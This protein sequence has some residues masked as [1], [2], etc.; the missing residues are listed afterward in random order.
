MPLLSRSLRLPCHTEV[1]LSDF[2]V[3]PNLPNLRRVV[4]FPL[5]SF[6]SVFS[7]VN[8]FKALSEA[9]SKLLLNS[10]L[11]LQDGF[12]DFVKGD[13]VLMAFLGSSNF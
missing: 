4:T 11:G 8:D 10:P 12:D 3:D 6:I 13:G 7:F 5:R 1:D 2:L 9:P